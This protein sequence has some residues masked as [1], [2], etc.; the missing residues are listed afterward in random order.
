MNKKTILGIAVIALVAI[1]AVTGCIKK[2]GTSAGS[3]GG[4]KSL[5]SAT[6]LKEY[7]DK[8]PAN[9]PD[10]PIKVTMKAND[11]MIKDIA[12]V[13]KNAGKYVSLDISG[14]SL[15]EIPGWVFNEC[16]T[17]VSII[18]PNS[19]TSIEDSAFMGCRNITSVIIPINVTKIRRN[20]F[21]G[22]TNLASV[23]FQGTIASDN[24]G[25]EFGN[26]TPFNGDLRVKYLAGG[27]GT[28][29]TTAPVDYNN[30]TWIRQ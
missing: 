20:V 4:D 11:M 13:I 2:D 18:I 27:A 14:S 19:V 7:L 16:N 28:Y 22:C 10:N 23:T 25:D 29:T 3:G 15:T 9:N 21:I 17:L 24:F 5:N 30:S 26:S 8:Q 6:E 12:E 1:I